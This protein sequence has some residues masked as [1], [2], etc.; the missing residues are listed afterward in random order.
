ME[1]IRITLLVVAACGRGGQVE[2]PATPTDN[3]GYANADFGPGQV[4]WHTSAQSL[5]SATSATAASPA[6]AAIG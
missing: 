2:P 3:F 1:R 5:T 6:P 4:T